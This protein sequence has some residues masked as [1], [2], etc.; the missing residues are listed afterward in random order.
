M[1]SKPPSGSGSAGESSPA[2]ELMSFTSRLLSFIEQAA[3]DQGKRV[4]GLNS[5]LRLAQP[6]WLAANLAY[7]KDL[8]YA[9]KE[10]SCSAG[11]HG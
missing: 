10:D 9:E 11:C 3:L 4:P 7:V 2:V 8:D 6:Q 1:P 5:F